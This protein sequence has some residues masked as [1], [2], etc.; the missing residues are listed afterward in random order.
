MSN[1][2][3]RPKPAS[4]LFYLQSLHIV[5]S[6]TAAGLLGCQGASFTG[7]TAKNNRAASQTP[8]PTTKTPVPAVTTT[9][10]PNKVVIE[11]EDTSDDNPQST[12]APPAPAGTEPV[13][14]D[15]DNSAPEPTDLEQTTTADEQNPALAN[16]EGHQDGSENA[17]NNQ[18]SNDQES[19]NDAQ[20]PVTPQLTDPNQDLPIEVIDD[21]TE[22]YVGF[23][24]EDAVDNDHNDGILCFGGKFAINYESGRVVALEPQTVAAKIKRNSSIAQ[25]IKIVI[26]RANGTTFTKSFNDLVDDQ[27]V[28]DTLVFYRGDEL[29]VNFH[30]KYNLW[31]QFEYNVWSGTSPLSD[32]IVV[33]ADNC[34]ITG[35]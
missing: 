32:R 4:F 27:L 34:R 20:P 11:Q 26:A 12:D 25:N 19:R 1:R 16:G 35:S 9:D 5:L 33:E 30:V 3:R 14:A 17:P 18:A 28:T 15:P 24:F 6:L 29:K 22:K 8:T 2:Y 23:G 7:G 13:V 31:T 10:D 21:V